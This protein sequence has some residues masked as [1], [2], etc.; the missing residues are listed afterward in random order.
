MGSYRDLGLGFVVEKG[1]TYMRKSTLAAGAF[2]IGLLGSTAHALTPPTISIGIAGRA[3]F[4]R[5]PIK[6]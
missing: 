5:S 1:T 2:A 6:W 3:M 4:I